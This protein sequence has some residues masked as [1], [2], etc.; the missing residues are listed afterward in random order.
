MNTNVLLKSKIQKLETEVLR[1]KFSYNNLN[2]KEVNFY[3]SLTPSL[4]LWVL[5][6]ISPNVKSVVQILS[7]QDHLLMILM[8]IRLG[9]LNKDLAFRFSVSEATVSRILH[10]WIPKVASSL[11]CLIIW[12]ENDVTRSQVPESF[13]PTYKKVVSTIDCFEVFTERPH[14]LTARAQT[15]SNYK[16]NNTVKYLVSITPSGAVNFISKGWGG[17]VSDKEI[18]LKSGYTDKLSHGDE[19]LADRGFLVSQELAAIG[20]T[21]RMPSFTRGKK[22]LSAMEV[23]MSKHLSNVRIHVERVIGKM[24]NFLILQTTIPVNQVKLLDDIVIIVAALTNLLP[25]VVPS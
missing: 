10:Q 23:H 19:V 9:C 15:W 16:H 1:L 24:R 7:F 14:N 2:E 11:K 25:S 4:F 8:K 21:L 13:K 6:K 17:R 18:T 22:Q 5:Q 12:P 20:V 3:T